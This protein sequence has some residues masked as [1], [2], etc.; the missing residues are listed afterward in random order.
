M[1]RAHAGLVRLAV[2]VA[3]T[4][5]GSIASAQSAPKAPVTETQNDTETKVHFQRGVKLYSEEDYRA[6]LVEF[7]RAYD[8]S[9]NRAILYNIGQTYFQLREYAAALQ[10]LEEYLRVQ[11]PQL[12]AQRRQQ[13][14]KDIEELNG[15]VAKVTIETNVPGAQITVDDVS[16]GASPVGPVDVSAGLRKFGATKDGYVPVVQSVEL[17]GGDTTKVRLELVAVPVE[18]PSAP[19]SDVSGGSGNPTSREPL[20]PMVF[21]GYGAGVVGLA[22]GTVFGA[23]AL[24]TKSDLDAR[25]AD[26]IC[27][28]SERN[29]GDSLTLQATASTIGFGVG[30]I[31]VGIGTYFLL[32]GQERT[33]ASTG[34]V[35]PWFAG[36]S[37]GIGGSF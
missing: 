13:V 5:A 20:S 3:T 23:I 14:E 6:A 21:V 2:L 37:A 28:T 30:L 24:G 22:A 26:R 15:R 8:L 4:L 29:T 9:A 35:T 19:T 34:R 17:A 1:T 12:P 18:K 16:V 36:T 27:P 31:G 10:T 25:C 11:G 32:T 7:K 33:T